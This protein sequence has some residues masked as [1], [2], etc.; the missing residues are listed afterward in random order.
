MKE[1]GVIDWYVHEKGFG[2]IKSDES[3]ERVLVHCDDV[4]RSDEAKF[5]EGL[6]VS[7]ERFQDRA[8]NVQPSS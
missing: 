7:F 4:R 1:T 3:E 8:I 2:F 6:A 5:K